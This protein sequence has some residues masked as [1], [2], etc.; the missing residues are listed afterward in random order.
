MMILSLFLL[1]A[2]KNTANKEWL[3][4]INKDFIGIYIYVTLLGSL[5]D[6]SI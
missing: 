5:P 1:L 4:K 6:S 2:G 3:F